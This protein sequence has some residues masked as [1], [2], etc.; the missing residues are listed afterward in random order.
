MLRSV[1][2]FSLASL[3]IDTS[4][5]AAEPQSSYRI[6][7]MTIVTGPPDAFYFQTRGALIPGSPHPTIVVTTQ[8]MDRTGTHAYRDMFEIRSTD[9][10][11]SWTSPERIESL[12][13]TKQENGFEVVAG[14]LSPQWHAATGVVLSTGKTFNFKDGTREDRSL[15]KVAYCVYDPH[16]GKWSDLRILELPKTDHT[17]AAIVCPN[18]GCCQRYDLPNGD[19]LLPIRYCREKSNTPYVTIVARCRFDG[20]TLRYVEHGTELTLDRARGLYEPSVTGFRGRYFLTMRADDSAFVA[21]SSDRIDYEP[22]IE[23]K[24]DDGIPLGSYNTQ[25]HWITHSDALYLCYTRRGANNDHI[26]RHRAPLFIARV[27]P[28][29]LCVLRATEETLLPEDNAALGNGGVMD[30]SRHETWV[31]ESEGLQGP[32]KDDRNKVLVAKILWS[33]PNEHF[34]TTSD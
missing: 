26:F 25:Q 4:P 3:S 14:D 11:Q 13:R 18:T 12:R 30:V 29:R 2:L 8:E 24:F 20:E 16:I 5:G 27:D 23:W 10:G 31:I 15:E 7:R 34:Q 22:M 28:E 9:G 19:I 1:L 32:R 17:G 6:E 21:R 33:R